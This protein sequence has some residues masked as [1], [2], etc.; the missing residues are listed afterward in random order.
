VGPAA[1]P[2]GRRTALEGCCL[3]LAPLVR[4]RFLHCC[5]HRSWKLRWIAAS[6]PNDSILPTDGMIRGAL[7]ARKRSAVKWPRAPVHIITRHWGDLT[8]SG[9]CGHHAV[10]VPGMPTRCDQPLA[11]SS[12]G[13]SP[14]YDSWDDPGST[15]VGDSGGGGCDTFA[16]LACGARRRRSTGSRS[17]EKGHWPRPRSRSMNE[18]G[19]V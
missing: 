6:G 16:L 7:E 15:H 3:F 12:K 9:T 14:R 19:E 10:P 11:P 5:G 17:R 8:K 13:G 2:A 4:C 1:W 18:R